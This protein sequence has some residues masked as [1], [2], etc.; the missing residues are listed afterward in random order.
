MKYKILI[1]IL[2]VFLLLSFVNAKDISEL[3]DE[4]L[5]N[6]KYFTNDTLVE[7][8]G[9]N[10]NIPKGFGSLKDYDINTTLNNV[11]TYCTFYVNDDGDVLMLSTIS[12]DNVDL[13]LDSYDTHNDS[14][15][16][17]KIVLNDDKDKNKKKKKG[18]C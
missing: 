18:C 14:E 11:T 2:L 13:D 12:G 3:T 15:K 17:T 4:E 16:K 9:F 5:E 7:V 10:F 8:N 1:G 6:V